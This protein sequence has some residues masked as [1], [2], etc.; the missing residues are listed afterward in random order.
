MQQLINDVN[1]ALDAECYYAAL[2]LVLTFLDICGKVEYPQQKVL[3]TPYLSG[4]V[5]YSLRNSEIPT[6]L[7][8]TKIIYG[9][10]C[11]GSY[12]ADLQSACDYVNKKRLKEVVNNNK[13]IPA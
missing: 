12:K 2:S 1:K 11:S 3:K 8:M 4:E 6:N 7:V 5:V 13:D 10:N 9:I